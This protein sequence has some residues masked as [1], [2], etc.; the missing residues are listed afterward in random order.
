MLF[1]SG[2]DFFLCIRKKTNMISYAGKNHVS[3]TIK[4]C[5]IAL[6]KKYYR[7]VVLD[8]FYCWWSIILLN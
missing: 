6:K 5:I 8:E 4:I 7:S 3:P 2:P 1:Y